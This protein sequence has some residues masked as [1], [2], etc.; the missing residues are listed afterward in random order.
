MVAEGDNSVL[1]QKVTKELMTD[2]QNGD[3]KPP[4][5]RKKLGESLE[6]DSLIDLLRFREAELVN[7]LASVTQSKMMNGKSIYDIWMKEENELVQNIAHSFGERVV[8]ELCENT[9]RKCDEKLFSI[10]KLL[11]STHLLAAI[12]KNLSW[13]LLKQSISKE[14][15]K[16]LQATL[17]SNISSIHGIAL[18][19]VES[20]G[21]P[22]SSFNAPIAKDYVDFNSRPNRGEVF[23]A[24]L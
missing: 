1:M 16:E 21:I 10:V 12:N 15:A 13:F 2:F 8:A 17:R 9:M 14:R 4:E 3:Y 19:V 7:E 11:L 22:E 18:Q 5:T 20:F 24:K 23:D 6:I